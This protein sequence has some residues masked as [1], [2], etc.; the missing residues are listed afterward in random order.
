MRKVH[1]I[2]CCT[3]DSASVSGTADWAKK[4]VACV[5]PVTDEQGWQASILLK[6]TVYNSRTQNRIY[7][8]KFFSFCRNF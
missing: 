6:N 7:F 5:L 1:S 8:T 2:H 4:E 3:D